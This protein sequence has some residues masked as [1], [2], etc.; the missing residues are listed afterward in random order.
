MH[1]SLTFEELNIGDKETIKVTVNKD[2]V[3]AFADATGDYNPIHVDE[4]Y[5]AKSQFKKTI[6]HGVLLTG[7]ISGLLGTKLP[8]LGTVAREMNAKFTHP[9]FV[10]EELTAEVEVIK[11]IDKIKICILKYRVL[12]A[13]GKVVV[14]GKA[15]VIPKS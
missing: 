7:I 14:K 2:K 6:V 5:A 12:N 10:G 4:E 3:D 9:A 13:A 8:G 11:K 15:K 1:K